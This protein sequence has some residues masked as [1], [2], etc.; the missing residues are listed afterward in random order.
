M[1]KD[2]VLFQDE[3]KKY[4]K[5]FQLD[6]Y[7]VYF[8][9]EPID[10]RVFSNISIDQEAMI[11]T[12]RFNNKLSKDLKSLR[13]PEWTAKHEAIHLLIGRL[14]DY[15]ESKLIAER[16]ARDIGEASEELVNKLMNLIKEE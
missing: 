3:F 16:D 10:E 1:N 13:K 12:V 5:L 8:K 7:N 4:Q 14:V 6:N 11:A 15:A 9:Y 2:F